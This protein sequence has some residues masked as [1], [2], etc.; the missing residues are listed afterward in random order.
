VSILLATHG[1]LE[2]KGYENCHS[3][4]EWVILGVGTKQKH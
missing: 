3:G 1:M 4:A 2:V